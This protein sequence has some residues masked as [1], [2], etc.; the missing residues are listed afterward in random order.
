MALLSSKYHQLIPAEEYLTD[1]V[2]LAQAWKKSHQYIRSTNWYADIFELDRSAINLN[3]RLDCWIEQLTQEEF[4]YIPLKLVP[5]PKSQSWEF[6]EPSYSWKPKKYNSKESKVQEDCAKPLRPLAHISIRDQTLTTALMMCIA[7]EVETLQGDTATD[8]DKVHGKGVVNY[9]NRL[10]CKFHNDRADFS[11]GNSVT[12]SKYFSDY[13]RFLARP[14]YFG[15]IGL[16][17]KLSKEDIYEVHLDIEQ[18]Y[19]K[20]KRALLVKKIRG[21]IKNRYGSS[22]SDA[23]LLGRMLNQLVDWRWEKSSGD[24]YKDVCAKGGEDEAPLGIPQGLVAGGFFANIYLNEFDN[25]IATIIGKHISDGIR[26][27]DYCRY[28]DDMRLIVI[29]AKNNGPAIQESIEDLFKE[30]LLELGLSLNKEKTIVKPYRVKNSGVSSKLRE[31]QGKLSGP[32]SAGEV[33]EQLGHIE[34]L[35][36]LAEGL[37]AQSIDNENTNPLALIDRPSND[38]REGTLLRFSANKIHSLLKQKRS[39][40]AQEVDKAG[41][42]VPGNW[43]Y[44][45]ERIARKLIAS[46]SYDPSLVLLLKKGLELFPDCRILKPIVSQL[47]KVID[48]N[49]SAREKKTAEYCLCEIFRH[50][51]TI[52]HDKENWASPAHANIREYHERL[53]QYA[54]DLIDNDSCKN[55]YLV[56]QATFYLLVSNDSILENETLDNNFNFIIKIMKGFRTICNNMSVS[57]L[58]TNSILAFQLSKDKKAVIRSVSS[59]VEERSKVFIY[60]GGVVHYNVNYLN[61]NEIYRLGLKMAQESMIFLKELI[62]HARNND[63]YWVTKVT[64]IAKSSAV[65][66]LPVAG[67]LSWFSGS[68]T[69][70]LSLIGV[71]KRSDNPFSHE[72]AILHLIIGLFRAKYDFS[73]YLDI[74][75]CRISCSD[76][77]SIQNLSTEIKVE[78]NKVGAEV[79]PIP[80]WVENKHKPLYRLGVFIRSCLLG[81]VDWTGSHFLHSPEAK[82]SGIKTSFYKR[83]LGMIHSPES[84]AGECAPMSN[85]LSELLSRLLQWPGA[86]IHEGNYSWPKE[87]SLASVRSL[88]ENRIEEQK[89]MYCVA[90]S[91]PAYT[92]RLSLGWSI[93]KSSLTVVMVQSMLPLKKDFSEHGLLLNTDS[94]RARH[95]RHVASVAELLLHKVHSQRS[96]KGDFT[97]AKADIDLI[98]WPELSINNE[99]ID[100]LK[101]LSDKTGAII[102]TGLVFKKLSGVDG[103]NNVAL[104]IVPQ[105]HDGGRQF[106]TRLQGKHNLMKDEVGKVKPWRP[107]QLMLELLHPAYPNEKGFVLTGSI[108]YDATDIK[109]S[110]DLKNKSDA[111]IISALNM[112]VATFDSM[113]DALYYHMFQH[114]T[115]VNTGEFGGS[116]AKAPYKERHEK[117]ITH[118]HGAGQVS[119]SSFEMNMFDFRNIGKNLR[120]GKKIKTKPA[121]G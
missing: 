86:K 20:V 13:R 24:L 48:G 47:F 27:I 38:V 17:Q 25:E 60:K 32:L 46:W 100:I 80:V 54:V 62:L 11:W 104:W 116:V 4:C 74:A 77:N 81:S 44:L 51:A 45:Q 87:W 105:K 14:S 91:M 28:V 41:K 43:D 115:L 49:S 21:I 90:S 93:E 58:V 8:L 63:Y 26:L 6:V 97:N 88:V 22:V 1:K 78:P 66:T 118:V 35:I 36:G 61:D 103:P 39:L 108:C 42:P 119:I 19:D 73:S 37:R 92:E 96:A 98:V 114:V 34:G 99:D 7:G 57:D 56:Q 55:E 33:D 18:F 67:N 113:V 94:Y 5:A 9:G 111:Y 72:N 106:L 107:Y 109:L 70:N 75:N 82:Y 79:F 89:K 53:Q 29:G 85:W 120:S 121:G 76:W 83:Q 110:A 50:S 2:V 117:L 84:L 31:I 102:F 95:R 23:T 3:D 68:E 16:Q 71:L 12:Y 69:V 40:I 101:R 64:S 59:I 15:S 10:F 112:D 52:I 30:K 65:F